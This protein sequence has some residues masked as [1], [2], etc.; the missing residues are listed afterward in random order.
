[1]R[2]QG[3]IM[4]FSPLSP[5]FAKANIVKLTL[6]LRKLLATLGMHTWVHCKPKRT[7]SSPF[8]RAMIKRPCDL[9]ARPKLL[10]RKTQIFRERI[11][12]KSRPR[13]SN[14]VQS[15]MQRLEEP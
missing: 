7:D 12:Q 1:M 2:E 10:Y 15:A 14:F 13:F 5:T 8:I 9:Q 4:V 3:S 6:R 11:L